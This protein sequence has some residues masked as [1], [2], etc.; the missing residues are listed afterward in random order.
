MLEVIEKSILTAQYNEMINI[1]QNIEEELEKHK[2]Q[3]GFI[4]IQTMH[5]TTGITV[6]ESLE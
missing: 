1:T 5:T 2:I 3:E 6:N 4:T